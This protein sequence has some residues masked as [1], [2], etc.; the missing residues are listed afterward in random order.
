M[1][2]T[3]T[4]ELPKA[5]LRGAFSALH[6]GTSVHTMLQ[7]FGGSAAE[8]RLLY[9]AIARLDNEQTHAKQQPLR[10]EFVSL[11]DEDGG[12]FELE[13]PWSATASSSN[14]EAPEADVS[15]RRHVH[16]EA[17]VPTPA[18]EGGMPSSLLEACEL[19]GIPVASGSGGNK[20]VASGGAGSST[21]TAPTPSK[22]SRESESTAS[23][24]PSARAADADADAPVTR[25]TARAEDDRCMGSPISAC[26]PARTPAR[27]K[28]VCTPSTGVGTTH[29]TR[30]S[31]T[32]G[33]QGRRRLDSL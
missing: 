7:T 30:R 10:V 20:L 28:R 9:G 32:M 6:E 13:F 21:R 4:S 11:H 18:R 17:P 25:T 16:R 19:L 12:T 31:A 8:R 14:A 29:A 33:H 27:A 5:A 1:A 15:A 22:A 24:T 26:S 3:I 23:A 2:A